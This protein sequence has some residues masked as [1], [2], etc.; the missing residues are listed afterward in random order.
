MVS[1][2]SIVWMLFGAALLAVPWPATADG[3]YQSELEAWRRNREAGLKAEDG[4]L[5]VS[6]LYWLREGQTRVGS[7]PS[8]DLVLPSHAPAEVGVITLKNGHVAFQAAKGAGVTLAGKPFS[9]GPIQSDQLGEPDV[10]KVGDL[11][12]I[13]IKR[14]ARLAIRLKDN[15]SP[16]RTSFAGLRFY[17]PRDDW[18]IQ[19]KFVP[20]ASPVKLSFDTIVGETEVEE[21]PGYVVF[22]YGGQEYRLQAA[23][24]KDG[25]LWLVFRD[26][27]SGRTTHGGARQLSTAPPM[28]DKVE[29]DF[30]KAVNLPCAYIPFATCPLAPPQNRLKVAIEAGELKYEPRAGGS[31]AAH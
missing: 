7:D 20:Y 1:H 12:L 10:L 11:R 30:N 3:P 19:A 14:G 6:G 8:N 9:S 17:P 4:W 15:Q 24:L 23:R 18:R 16:L 25:G 13:A 2:P 31:A 21:S 5:S 29:L 26:L 22:E 28:G 27:T